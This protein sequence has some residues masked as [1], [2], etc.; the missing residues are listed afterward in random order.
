MSVC[1]DAVE[2]LRCSFSVKQQ[3]GAP[4]VLHCEPFKRCGEPIFR[5]E[6]GTIIIYGVMS[7]LQSEWPCRERVMHPLS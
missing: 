1:C 6:P 5:F 4:F 7:A 2:E 3:Q